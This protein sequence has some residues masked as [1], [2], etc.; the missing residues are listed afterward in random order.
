[1]VSV[2]SRPWGVLPDPE[3]ERVVI[4]LEHAIEVWD[5]AASARL[6]RIEGAFDPKLVSRGVALVA[7]RSDGALHF[8]PLDPA[9]PVVS[10]ERSGRLLTDVVPIDE[11]FVVGDWNGRVTMRDA[12]GS[13]VR[14]LYT[15]EEPRK[16]VRV[17]AIDRERALLH[18]AGLVPVVVRLAD[19]AIE[20]TLRVNKDAGTD[21]VLRVDDA[22]V[23][24][25]AA[26]NE[27][28]LLSLETGKKL[29]RVKAKQQAHAGALR[30]GHFLIGNRNGLYLIDLETGVPKAQ[31]A[32][33][34][35]DVLA[36][37]IDGRAFGV[38][39]DYQGV[40]VYGP[41]GVLASAPSGHAERI[42]HAR[43]HPTKARAFT[44]SHD[45]TVAVW[46]L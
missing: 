45:G 42:A 10:A 46:E 8:V 6:R 38:T 21:Q 9:E 28:V 32:T 2:G 7:G 12:R 3:S 36:D 11:G 31:I 34:S 19:G 16:P 39:G 35:V 4:A 40:A 17:T 41:S 25:Y 23:L 22:Q 26:P 5:L 27:A 44:W 14:T 30:F 18:G 43:T 20:R 13:V 33:G 29:W 24:V 15:R 1:M 37:V